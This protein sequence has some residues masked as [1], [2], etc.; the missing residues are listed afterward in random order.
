MPV[1]RM[2]IILFASIW[3]DLKTVI[4][5]EINETDKRKYMIVLTYRI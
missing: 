1:R 3:M 2:K 4:V 5:S